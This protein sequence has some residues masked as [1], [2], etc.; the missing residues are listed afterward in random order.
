MDFIHYHFFL[1]FII[2]KHWWKS[3]QN[4]KVKVTL[5]SSTALYMY[6]V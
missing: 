6:K 5:L 3:K 1:L 4:F 2:C